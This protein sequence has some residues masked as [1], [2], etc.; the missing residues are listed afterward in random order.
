MKISSKLKIAVFMGGRSSEHEVSLKSGE[1]I[2]SSIDTEK[3]SVV[4]VIINKNG[5]WNIQ[6][7]GESLNVGEA[8]GYIKEEKIS[9][10]FLALH[11][12]YGED[13]AI[14][15]LLEMLDIAYT[16]S[17]VLSSS[18]A[19]HKV[20]TLEMYE[21]HGFKTPKRIVFSRWDSKLIREEQIN[22]TDKSI[23]FPCIVK[24]SQLGS[25]VATYK[26]DKVESLRKAITD[27]CRY[28]VDGLIEEYI[29]GSEVT[30]AVL[31]GMPG[32]SPKAL[33]P[34]LIK[35][36]KSI[37]FDYKAKYTSGASEEIT[38]APL[39]KNLIKRI[40]NAAVKAHQILGCG[41]LSR[42]DMIIR[43]NTLY[44]L[45]TNTIPGM[46]QNSLFP[47]AANAAGISLTQLCNYLILHA[48]RYYEMKQSKI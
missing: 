9:V 34:T 38:P 16:G 12:K 10:A 39:P 36:K 29:L 1:V 42:T 25:S 21:Y 3:Y 2:C 35:P 20:K 23:G 14:Q 13:G 26:V 8:I 40:Q 43:D 24:P 11:G 44:L 46:T 22:K 37:F 4:P 5:T 28:D 15:G 6:P 30:C 18:L 19:M 47:Q 41:S 32:E 7:F 17:N 45:E 31:G 33:P 27:V 48:L